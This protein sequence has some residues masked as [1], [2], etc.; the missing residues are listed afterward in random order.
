MN[1]SGPLWPGGLGSAIFSEGRGRA[2]QTFIIHSWER[3]KALKIQQAATKSL[4][5]T[6]WRRGWMCG[7]GLMD[8]IVIGFLL[9]HMHQCVCVSRQAAQKNERI[10]IIQKP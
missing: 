8:K 5:D 2:N 6:D 4:P 9:G 10:L 3:R 7:G 1:I